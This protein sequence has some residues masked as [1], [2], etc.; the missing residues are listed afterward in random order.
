MPRDLNRRVVLDKEHFF[1]LPARKKLW[2]PHIV[3]FSK[4]EERGCLS[5]YKPP[6]SY[7]GFLYM[8]CVSSC[9]ILTS[10]RTSL[11]SEE[12]KIADFACTEF[13]SKGGLPGLP[14][15]LW[16]N[17]TFFHFCPF[18]FGVLCLHSHSQIFTVKSSAS[19]DFILAIGKALVLLL[20][21]GQLSNSEEQVLICWNFSWEDWISTVQSWGWRI[22]T[23]MGGG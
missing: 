23:W 4:R 8:G 16:E 15:C 2:S 10:L 5:V 20:L 13:T 3:Q 1:L 12:F 7:L 9:W 18:D 6:S 22:F 17:K 19:K 14:G 21:C 11:N